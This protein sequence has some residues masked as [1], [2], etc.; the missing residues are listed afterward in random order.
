MIKKKKAKLFDRVRRGE[1]RGYVDA[2]SPL[3]TR[4]CRVAWDHGG[5]TWVYK[6]DLTIE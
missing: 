6:S 1:N 5:T 2:E 4:R 3:S